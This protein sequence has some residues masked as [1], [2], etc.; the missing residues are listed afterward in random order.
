ML[1]EFSYIKLSTYI[2]GNKIIILPAERL[3]RTKIPSHGTTVPTHAHVGKVTATKWSS[4]SG[5]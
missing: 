4:L 3:N 1:D 5:F 2:I